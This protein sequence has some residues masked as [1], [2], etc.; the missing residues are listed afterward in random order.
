MANEPGSDSDPDMMEEYD[1]TKGGRG[2][3]AER[4][5]AG[6]NLVALDPDVA[7]V[8]P[9]SASVNRALRALSLP[10]WSEWIP[11]DPRVIRSKVPTCI[12]VYRSRVAGVSDRLVYIGRTIAKAGLAGRLSARAGSVEHVLAQNENHKFQLAPAEKLIIARGGSLEVSYACANSREEA[13]RWEAELINEYK[14]VH[15]AIPPGNT[16]T[17]ALKP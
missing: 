14:S 6:N 15:G 3:Y 8:F 1:F 12:G 5:A 11:L 4:Y 10:G 9:D 13:L 17:P 7:E 2:K 16:Q